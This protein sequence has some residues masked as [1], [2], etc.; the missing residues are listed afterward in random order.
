M[1]TSI[2]FRLDD[3]KIHSLRRR[4]AEDENV[5]LNTF[6]NYLLSSYLEWDLISAKEAEFFA[7]A[8]KSVLRA[9]FE[10]M[11]DEELRIMAVISANRFKDTA[12]LN[13][14][15]KC[16]MEDILSLTASR[17][18]RSGFNLRIFDD[19]DGDIK[20][21]SMKHDMGYR[22]SIFFTIFMMKLISDV[23]YTA[24]SKLTYNGWS[25]ELSKV[26]GA[27]ERTSSSEIE[28]WPK[29]KFK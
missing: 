24:K 10:K 8:N 20:S 13:N 15:S 11:S 23:G 19:A 6:V 17:A 28:C 5:S 27:N 4:L 3:D 21:L 18:K 26:T 29:H 9:L 1:I 16:D 12:V 14:Y 2:T 25:M 7:P 22:W